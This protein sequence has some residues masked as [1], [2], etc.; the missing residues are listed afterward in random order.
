V[1]IEVMV[2]RSG[3]VSRSDGERNWITSFG[4]TESRV[5]CY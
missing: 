3:V 5:W 1:K 2:S 4:Y